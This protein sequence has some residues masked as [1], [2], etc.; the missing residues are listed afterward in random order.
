MSSKMETICRGGRWD[1]LNEMK[2]NTTKQWNAGFFGACRGGH[3]D[4]ALHCIKCGAD[5][6]NIY[7]EGVRICKETGGKAQVSMIDK[8]PYPP[9]F[10]HCYHCEKQLEWTWDDPNLLQKGNQCTICFNKPKKSNKST[11]KYQ[12][13]IQ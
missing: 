1:W 8:L 2:N 10:V 11:Q 5:Y 13:N 3:L 6:A 12:I 7:A 4:L 9:R